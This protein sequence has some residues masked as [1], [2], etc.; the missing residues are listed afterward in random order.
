MSNVASADDGVVRVR[1]ADYERLLANML[2]E[3]ESRVSAAEAETS[4]ARDEA[5]ALRAE[6][7]RALARESESARTYETWRD[8][9]VETAAD[10]LAAEASRW[11]DAMDARDDIV[12]S[13]RRDAD[14][15]AAAA[16]AERREA[17]HADLIRACIAEYPE[18][19]AFWA[20]A[21]A[22]DEA[23]ARGDLARRV[24]AA[25]KTSVEPA[26][27]SSTGAP[28]TPVRGTPPSF[29]SPARQ[30][31]G[32]SRHG[33]TRS[34]SFAAPVATSSSSAAAVAEAKEEAARRMAEATARAG[35]G[36]TAEAKTDGGTTTSWLWPFG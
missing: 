10:E 4:C 35:L 16:A 30:S 32:R 18:T 9:L 8:A 2:A 17:R 29:E 21:D 1:V 7:D 3:A 25:T 27:T 28:S 33:R 19:A 12:E 20:A 36:E 23:E 31:P 24:D 26:S 22:R 34:M 11:R 6:L 15:A 5:D 14:A 13:T